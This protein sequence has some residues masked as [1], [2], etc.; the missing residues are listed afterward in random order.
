MDSEDLPRLIYLVLLGTVV[1]G[2]FLMENRDRLGKT[3]QQAA[4]WAL[5]FLGAIAVAGVWSDIRRGAYPTEAVV[6]GDT[7]EVPVANDGHF[8]LAA[9]INGAKVLFVVD[10][11]ASEIVLTRRDAE[12]AGLDPDTLNFFG[13]AMTANGRVET[14]PVRLESFTLGGQTDTNL[15]AV[16]N[17]GE[18]DT[19]LLGMSYLG[20]FE[21]ILRPDRLTLRR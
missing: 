12:R 3:A 13:S 18:L 9:E 11:G 1:G 16:V 14:A 5:I 8:Y 10:T 17:G 19:S 4:I 15:P 20:R 2:Y 6:R 7:L 21:M